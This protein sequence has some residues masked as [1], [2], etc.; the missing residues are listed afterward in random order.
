MWFS[1]VETHADLCEGDSEAVILDLSICCNGWWIF[2]FKVNKVWTCCQGTHGHVL[3]YIYSTNGNGQCGPVRAEVCLWSSLTNS[4]QMHKNAHF[5]HTKRQA[6][7]EETVSF[8]QLIVGSHLPGPFGWRFG[9]RGRETEKE[10]ARE[11]ESER[12]EREGASCI[13][14]GERDE[15]G[16]REHDNNVGFC[17]AL[18]F[19][20][21]LSD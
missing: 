12:G 19:V 11:G 9:E 6:M 4:A 10:E 16:A 2:T 8:T 15:G 14:W 5:H 21:V 17:K 7:Y 1:H 20:L 18:W 13:D 3:Q